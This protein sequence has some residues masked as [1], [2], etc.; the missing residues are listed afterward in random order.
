MGSVAVLAKIAVEIEQTIK[1]K[2]SFEQI[3]GPVLGSEE[4]IVV[5][6]RQ[7]LF[8]SEQLTNE[9]IACELGPGRQSTE[10]IRIYFGA[11][12]KIKAHMASTGRV[13]LLE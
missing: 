12:E 7:G 3:F 1:S 8:G 9:E 11:L 5:V 13:R 4:M 2:E 10:V 6:G